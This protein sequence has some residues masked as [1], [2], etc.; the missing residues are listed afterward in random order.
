MSSG[1]KILLVH[2]SNYVAKSKV[3]SLKPHGKEAVVRFIDSLV[4]AK[5][6][7]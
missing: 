7:F 5:I 1:S 6:V 3:I 4:Q 2:K